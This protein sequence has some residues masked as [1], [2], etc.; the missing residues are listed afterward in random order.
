MNRNLAFVLVFAAA[1]TAFADDIT[2]DNTPFISTATRAQVQAELV[3][4]TQSGANPWSN[5]YNPLA[6]FSSQRT[7]AEVQAAYIASR[8]EVAALTGEDSG[9]AYLARTDDGVTHPT[10]M[11]GQPVNAQ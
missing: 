4:F 8:D 2:I 3:Q 1:G 6:G 9:S 10:R 11:A 7:R 5:R